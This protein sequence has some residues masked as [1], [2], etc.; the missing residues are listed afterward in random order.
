MANC[1]WLVAVLFHNLSLFVLSLEHVAIF[2]F[3]LYIAVCCIINEHSVDFASISHGD[4]CSAYTSSFRPLAFVIVFVKIVVISSTTP[5]IF[6]ESAFIILAVGKQNPNLPVHHWVTIK[7]S[8]DD[9]VRQGKQCA[10]AR[11]PSITPFS[12]VNRAC[13]PK[14]AKTASMSQVRFP[15]SFINISIWKNHLA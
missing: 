2:V 9:F 15:C 5:L 6:L 14:F 13:R 12:L 10:V 1:R 3:I 8:L 7:S 11:R 4:A